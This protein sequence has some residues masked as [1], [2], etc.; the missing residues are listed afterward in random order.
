M[1]LQG[2]F[3][4][5]KVELSQE[6][7]SQD[8]VD[9][10]ASFG[11]SQNLPDDLTIWN[12]VVPKGTKGA[13]YGLGS[14]GS[15]LSS[16]FATGTCSV[17]SKDANIEQELTK[18]QEKAKEQELINKEQKVKLDVAERKLEDQGRRLQI[19]QK[20]IESTENTLMTLFR[21][22]NMPLPPNFS[23]TSMQDEHGEPFNGDEGDNTGDD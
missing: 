2:E 10:E 22:L 4:K 15:H 17:T 23:T 5:R 1:V 21:N 16:K 6:A 11:G 13:I 20:R 7:S 18:W 12:E 19:Q 8:E 9:A 3:K 14:V